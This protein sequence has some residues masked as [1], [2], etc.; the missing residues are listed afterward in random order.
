MSNKERFDTLIASHIAQNL[1]YPLGA[2]HAEVGL[3][4]DEHTSEG[5]VQDQIIKML[6][7]ILPRP[8]LVSKG[9]ELLNDRKLGGCIPDILIERIGK[10]YWGGQLS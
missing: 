9:K 5:H 10:G 4:A 6:R 3:A 1:V 7:A 2:F 8:T